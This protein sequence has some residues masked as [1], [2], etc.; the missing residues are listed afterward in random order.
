M[1]GGLPGVLWRNGSSLG[2][3]WLLFSCGA[4]RDAKREPPQSRELILSRCD[5]D[6]AYERVLTQS[7]RARIETHRRLALGIERALK[8]ATTEAEREGLNVERVEN[9]QER[10]R[11]EAE[12]ALWE[13]QARN[14]NA[15]P[16]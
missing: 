14:E 4:V 11:L 15:K 2:G 8:T 12:L 5:M 7:L 6:P 3:T 10:R 1:R 16:N 9:A 13:L